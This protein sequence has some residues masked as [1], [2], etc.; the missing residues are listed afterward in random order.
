MEIEAT[1]HVARFRV[2]D[3]SDSE[4]ATKMIDTILILA[5]YGAFST[6]MGFRCIMP[7]TSVSHRLQLFW[8]R[9]VRAGIHP[10]LRQRGSYLESSR[11][12][13]RAR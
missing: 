11:F 8:H 2:D 13:T 4:Q 6:C 3:H 10:R 9:S 5:A 1:T 7:F 12:V